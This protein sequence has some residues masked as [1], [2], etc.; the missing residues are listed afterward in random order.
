MFV[1]PGLSMAGELMTF[2]GS[3]LLLV[4]GAKPSSGRTAKAARNLLL[5]GDLEHSRQQPSV[6][7]EEMAE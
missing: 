4:A 5:G 2:R 1:L 7:T 3:W 6:R